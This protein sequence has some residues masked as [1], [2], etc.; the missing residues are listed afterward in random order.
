MKVLYRDIVGRLTMS[1]TIANSIY[2]WEQGNS[3][4]LDFTVGGTVCRGSKNEIE[5]LFYDIVAA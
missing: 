3:Y 5:K 2:I 1:D 4:A